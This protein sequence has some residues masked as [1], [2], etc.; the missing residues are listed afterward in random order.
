[1]AF[2]QLLDKSEAGL[3]QG[4][5]IPLWNELC[6]I[7]PGV[8]NLHVQVPR[9]QSE[10]DRAFQASIGASATCVLQQCCLPSLRVR[11]KNVID[12]GKHSLQNCLAGILLEDRMRHTHHLHWL[13][14]APFSE[15][16]QNLPGALSHIAGGPSTGCFWHN[17]QAKHRPSHLVQYQAIKLQ[18]S[19]SWLLL[20]DPAV[21]RVHCGVSGRLIVAIV[22]FCNCCRSPV[23]NQLRSQFQGILSCKAKRRST[24]QDIS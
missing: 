17:I 20:Q 3:R 5:C 21:G 1:M 16:T 24:R 22:P 13:Y 10:L 4:P 14:V 18:V 19:L 7:V 23:L 9:S 12:K 8:V 15:Q 11:V 6:Q 2:T